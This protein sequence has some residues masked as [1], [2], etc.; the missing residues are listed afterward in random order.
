MYFEVCKKLGFNMENFHSM[1]EGKLLF[2][3]ELHS[4]PFVVAPLPFRL[5]PNP[6]HHNEKKNRFMSTKNWMETPKN[7]TC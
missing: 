2:L 1:Q 6:A 7:W 4:I 5:N 3:F